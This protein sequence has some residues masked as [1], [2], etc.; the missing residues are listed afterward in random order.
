[1][2][3]VAFRNHEVF[4]RSETCHARFAPAVLFSVSMSFAINIAFLT[5]RENW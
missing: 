1:M 3:I 5:E 4:C 2:F